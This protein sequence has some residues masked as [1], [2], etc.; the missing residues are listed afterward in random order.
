M[1]LTDTEIQSAYKV[2]RQRAAFVLNSRDADNLEDIVQ[3]AIMRLIE[4]PD[5]DERLLG[6]TQTIVD[7]KIIDMWRNRN[8]SAAAFT[9]GDW[10]EGGL[11]LSDGGAFMKTLEMRMDI[12]A[13]LAQLGEPYKTVM[14]QKFFGGYSWK[15]IAEL[16][17]IMNVA[18]WRAWF[19][20]A[21]R[22]VLK[23]FLAAYRNDVT[24]PAAETYS[25]IQAENQPGEES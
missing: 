16:H 23:Q 6:L 14:M 19:K 24:K 22:P 25:N 11:D 20:R 2:A 7:H 3:A 10:G 21:A 1:A 8:N 12:T 15:E 13:A 4:V 9:G 5:V 18:A 17:P